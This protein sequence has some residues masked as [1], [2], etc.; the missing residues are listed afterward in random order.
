MIEMLLSVAIISLIAGMGI[1]VYRTFQVRN[2]LDVATN[3]LAQSLRRAQI[4]A[5]SMEGDSPWGVA[6]S[7]GSITLFRGSS[8]ASRNT[9]YD[10][11]FSMPE[12]ITISGDSEY[13]FQKFTGDPTEDGS[14]DLTSVDQETRTL[15]LNEKGT[16]DY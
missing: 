8:Y 15:N 1:P 5:Q 6:L 3:T 12:N 13:T 10:E 7:T 11:V 9:D 2:D 14:T 16:V 4:L